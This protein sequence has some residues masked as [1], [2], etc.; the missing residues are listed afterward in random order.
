VTTRNDIL[1]WFAAGVIAAIAVAWLAA[2]VHVSGHAP[3]GLLSFGVGITLGATLHTI[4]ASGHRPKGGRLAGRRRLVVGTI[5]LALLTVLAQ[6]AWLYRD[7]RRQWHEA[8]GK[9][10]QVAMFRPETPWSPA[11]YFAREVT[12]TRVA[13]WCM[14]AALILTGAVG[15]VLLVDRKRQ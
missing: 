5:L 15:T 7:F 13:L 14:D 6:H 3:V 10:P 9:S 8:R 1:I 4:A 12:P 11:E 2:I